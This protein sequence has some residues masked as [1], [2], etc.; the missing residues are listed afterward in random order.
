M[1]VDLFAPE[2]TPLFSLGKQPYLDDPDVAKE[3]AGMIEESQL[4]YGPH[5]IRGVSSTRVREDEGFWILLI[6]SCY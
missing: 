1:V 5:R 2:E 4:D 3:E 6:C